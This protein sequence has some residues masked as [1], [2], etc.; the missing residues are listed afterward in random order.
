[1]RKIKNV[2]CP[3]CSRVFKG[4]KSWC[5]HV[6]TRHPDDIPEGF[7]PMRYLY[8]I[9]TG[10]Y[11][12]TC[13]Y[14]NNETEWNEA[15]GKYGRICGSTQCREIYAKNHQL[16]SPEKQREMLQKRKISS[17]YDYDG[18]ELFY[19]G[20]YELN[21]LKFMHDVM[22]WPA[23]DIMSPSPNTYY[24]TYKN[25]NDTYHEGEKFYIP[26]FYIP[27]LNLEI[28]IKDQTTTHP[29]FLKIDKIK[30]DCKDKKMKQLSNK[31]NYFKI[32]N[33][34]F[35]EFVAY[36]EKMKT[37]FSD[38]EMVADRIR[39]YQSIMSKATEGVED[40]DTAD[41][42]ARELNR[43]E[44]AFIWMNDTGLT[45]IHYCESLE[46]LEQLRDEW[47]E[48]DEV[49]KSVSDTQS[50][51]L[52]GMNN[53]DHYYFIKDL[54]TEST[55]F[56]PHKFEA[57]GSESFYGVEGEIAM[58]N[59]VFSSKP[60]EFNMM[61]WS[62]DDKPILFITG[63][64]GSGKSTLA[65][66]Y[67]SE[68][69]AI[70][71]EL[72]RYEFNKEIFDIED[73]HLNESE[74]ILKDYLIKVN[75]GSLDVDILD[76][77]EYYD[78]LIRYVKYLIDYANRYNRLMVIEGLQ[79]YNMIQF[80]NV[81]NKIDDFYHYPCIIL[82]TS[83]TKS[84]IQRMNRNKKYNGKYNM[85]DVLKKFGWYIDHDKR[86][87]TSKDMFKTYAS[88]GYVKAYTME[89][90]D[91]FNTVAMEASTEEV[92][93]MINK[94]A[95]TTT[96]Y[97]LHIRLSNDEETLKYGVVEVP[98]F[99][100]NTCSLPLYFDKDAGLTT[101]PNI[102]KL[103]LGIINSYIDKWNIDYKHCDIGITH[104]DHCGELFDWM[105]HDQECRKH[106]LSNVTSLERLMELVDQ[107]ADVDNEIIDESEGVIQL[108]IPIGRDLKEEINGIYELPMRIPQYR[109]FCVPMSI[110]LIYNAANGYFTQSVEPYLE[111]LREF[112][113]E[114]DK[115]E[116]QNNIPSETRNDMREFMNMLIHIN[117]SDDLFEITKRAD[118]V[119][120]KTADIL[121]EY[122][123]P[124]IEPH[125][126]VHY[127]TL[128]DQIAK[129]RTESII[130]NLCKYFDD[131]RPEMYSRI[132][133]YNKDK[134][135]N[136]LE[137][138]AGKVIF[139]TPYM[140]TLKIMN[141]LFEQY[142][143]S[144]KLSIL[145]ENYL[146]EFHEECDSLFIF[147]ITPNENNEYLYPYDGKI[148]AKRT[149][150]VTLFTNNL[151]N[152]S[153]N[154]IDAINDMS[155]MIGY[156]DQFEIGRLLG[157]ER[158]TANH[159]FEAME[160]F[161]FNRSITMNT[162]KLHYKKGRNAVIMFTDRESFCRNHPIL[163]GFEKVELINLDDILIGVRNERYISQIQKEYKEYSTV[164]KKYFNHH[165][166]NY[167]ADYKN[168]RVM[169]P[170]LDDHNE[171]TLVSIL[172]IVDSNPTTIYVIY[173]L[174]FIRYFYNFTVGLPTVIDDISYI[175]FRMTRDKSTTNIVSK[176]FIDDDERIRYQ[177]ALVKASKPIN[178]TKIKKAKGNMSDPVFY[179]V[180]MDDELSALI[181]RVPT[182]MM[183]GENL[184]IPRSCVS[185]TVSGCLMAIPRGRI[186]EG[187]IFY[188]YKV[189][190]VPG[191][192]YYMPSI[193]EVP[194]QP[195][196]GEH[197][198]L[199]DALLDF[200]YGCVITDVLRDSKGYMT[201]VKGIYISDKEVL[202]KIKS[203]G[204]DW[205]KSKP[206]YTG[207]EEVIIRFD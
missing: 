59:L 154:I 203:K 102:R 32:N 106:K 107:F 180:S 163:E 7:T 18:I 86:L 151:P 76:D 66:K 162:E 136:I 124:R 47:D 27:S 193:D 43:H 64:S 149:F 37:R 137:N 200:Q 81:E 186:E 93:N 80:Y 167:G 73:E 150:I 95:C 177:K 23:S 172:K 20:T 145:L 184:V 85:I 139:V 15:T 179:H 50:M 28:E 16:L 54:L 91:T 144:N 166:H 159:N 78:G 198:I 161:L 6:L 190:L 189:R 140:E 60:N 39:S 24:Y 57:G 105:N 108:P 51:N 2:K 70:Y 58:E 109:E 173:G 8:G 160:G 123:W 206:G 148:K 119:Y 153:C 130:L 26:D 98:V 40:R 89:V 125:K 129:L 30:E 90:I 165:Y 115:I 72:D 156:V 134:F 114:V 121:E 112:Y 31:V 82:N 94:V 135:M 14:C 92:Y 104:R 88:E 147:G 101:A 194:D 83:V 182:S 118:H 34:K 63:L 3:H 202:K 55:A 169:T 103:F 100:I 61:R 141:N 53:L 188:I 96:L 9:V 87:Q 187:N 36:L 176:L 158:Y 52:F 191:S 46:E 77:E 197:W 44:E 68:N 143:L 10:K 69:K 38:R 41:K 110:Q 205:H 133:I 99:Y 33:N 48:M 131:N 181:P 155:E 116:S 201:D 65:K 62:I 195:L 142:V 138:T 178:H 132:V 56:L 5:S 111:R 29:K 71:I 183:S 170:E 49:N 67:S 97:K 171:K 22:Q 157:Y 126:V 146:D 128:I 4:Q 122:Y 19:T 74:H 75:G 117:S 12:G 84:M 127:Q 25:S 1:M 174:A 199:S 120:Q 42:I 192:R 185:N 21:F 175:H 207:Q 79:I 13:M 17:V 164:A 45:L 35:G 168:Y 196:T 204:I 11:K 152:L 113:Q